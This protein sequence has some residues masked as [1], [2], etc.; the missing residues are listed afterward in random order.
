MSIPSRA[1]MR[2]SCLSAAVL[3]ALS[4]PLS[5]A[6]D[7]GL[8]GDAALQ[9]TTLDAIQVHGERQPLRDEQALTPG[10]VTVLDGESFHQRP[11]ANIADA[12][13]YVPGVWAVSSAGGDSLFISSR[14]SNLDATQ[15]DSNGVK[16]FQDGL[17]VSSADGN[18]HNRFLDPMA[19]RHAVVA[20]G[21]NALALGASNLGG[22]INFISPT[23]RNGVPGQVVVS[24]G[25]RG[26]LSGRVT[27]GG[28]SGDLDGLVTLEAR[29]S[30]GHRG[31]ARQERAGL[32]ANAGWRVSEDFDLRLFATYIDSDEELP[33]ALDRARF[34]ADPYQAD[35]SAISGDFQLNVRS[36]R[37][38]AKGSWDIDAHQRLEFGV[39]WEDQHLYHPIVDK[40][41]VERPAPLPPIEVFSLLKQTDQ[42]NLGGMLR[43]GVRAGEHDVLAGINLGYSHETGGNFRNDGGRRNGQTE[44]I[45]NRSD[46]VEVFVLDRWGFAP[47][48]TAV[49]GAQ[50]VV[51]GRDVR[52][53][54]IASG[55][56]RQLQDD[57]SAINPRL[58]VIRALGEGREAFASIGT[59]Y[60]APTT[61]ELEDDVRGGGETLDA[62][63]GSVLEFGLRGTTGVSADAAHWHWDASAYYARVRD[64]ILS[65]DDPDAPG[66]SLSTNVDRA[67]H[68]GIEALAGASLPLGGGHRIEPLLS[69]T[70]NAFSFDDDPLYGNNH[71]PAAPAYALRGE[72]LYRNDAGLF[73]GP[74]FDLVG[75][76][77]AD[78]SNDYRVGSH[79]LVGLRLG[80]EREGWE[81]FG[82]IRN[83]FDREHVGM[84]L[85]HD[86][87]ASDASVLHAGEPRSVYVGLRV[88][89]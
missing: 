39:S 15:Y 87:A 34:D 52:T 71:L 61:M 54:D 58:G 56:V 77:Y 17:P 53:G 29:R 8:A 86:R 1:T 4:F 50:G 5:A 67:I 2:S 60:E 40:V 78:F 43:Y 20:R 85:V 88:R 36:S 66:T 7:A 38:A 25:S 41:M 69:A 9:A 64:A 62:M 22:G 18:N 10:G 23:A 31:H 79:G 35:P 45:D 83:L 65:I 57:Y 19:A 70:W 24:G 28:V 63:R 72:V 13:R 76:R 46:S 82:E 48:W 26:T 55:A 3:A 21:A 49:Y 75:R 44:T 89:Y 68:A 37:L 74:T 12:L 27:A 42:E 47:G 84:L 33:G 30:D 32:Y 80:M 51:T 81:A 73:A 14:G 16:L 59:L 11:V 6:A